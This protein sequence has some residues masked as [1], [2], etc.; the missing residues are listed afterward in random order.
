[1]GA[2]GGT[3]HEC[4]EGSQMRVHA[5]RSE[6]DLGGPLTS[7]LPCVDEH[8][9]VGSSLGS[10]DCRSQFRDKPRSCRCSLIGCLLQYASRSGRYSKEE[11]EQQHSLDANHVF[12]LCTAFDVRGLK[13]ESADMEGAHG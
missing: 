11:A 2:A 9:H 4:I 8:R 5:A 13:R 7:F 12:W 10:L 1:M 3:V 6:R